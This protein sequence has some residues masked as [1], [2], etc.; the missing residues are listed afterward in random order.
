[1]KRS[2]CFVAL[3]VAVS[4][5]CKK[6]R[7]DSSDS[8]GGGGGSGGG[9]GGVMAVAKAPA[10]LV[11][12]AELKDLHLFMNTYKGANGRVPNSQETWAALNQAD[13]N[14]Q[15]AKLI[16][17][18]VIILVPNPPEEGLWAYAKDA[19][20]QGGWVLT[21]GGPQQMTAA[22]FAALQRGN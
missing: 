9:G 16:Q 7:D 15:L 5:G 22:E 21:H 12:A 19:P 3:T 11:T 1:M 8:Q 6:S 10:R 18:Q 2:L 17:D 20:T 13:G 14:R 4:G